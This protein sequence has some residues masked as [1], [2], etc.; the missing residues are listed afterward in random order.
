MQGIK[1]FLAFLMAPLIGAM[2]DAWGRKP[3]LLLAVGFTC[4]PLPFLLL[5]N[6][7]WHFVAVAL[8]GA[9]AVT[10]SIVFAYVGDI[11]SPLERSSAF[12]QVSA[13]FA[14]SM[15]ISPALGSLVQAYAGNT[16][17][18]LLSTLISLADM[19][20]IVFVVPE[21]KP[22]S[23]QPQ[24]T[25]SWATANP[26]QSMRAAFNSGPIML[27]SIVVFFSYL[28]EAG[29]YQCLM[30]Y[31]ENSAHFSKTSLALFIACLGSFSIVAQTYVP[32]SYVLAGQ[33]K[34]LSHASEKSG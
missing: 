18:F 17:V 12:G 30:L 9:F 15:V 16:A 32:L 4:L 21:S 5:H 13:T 27:L 23:E 7:L 25:I 22:R 2:S 3:F 10:F 11:T 19:L 34:N 31:L 14:A 8:S 29:E 6:L 20:F 33:K 28:P 1:G 26:F 24:R